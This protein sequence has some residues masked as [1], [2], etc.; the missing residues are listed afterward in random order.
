M[1]SSNQVLPSDYTSESFPSANTYFNNYDPQSNYANSYSPQSSYANNANPQSLYSNNRKM[2]MEELKERVFQNYLNNLGS[3]GLNG[4][5]NGLNL[6]GNSLDQ[7]LDIGN[8][9][10][11][12]Y[13]PYDRGNFGSGLNYG[14]CTEDVISAPILV[15]VLAGLAL[16]W[17]VLRE[18]IWQ[19]G[20]RRKKRQ[21]EEDEDQGGIANLNRFLFGNNSK[22]IT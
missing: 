15:T 13:D 20:G 6:V 7:G 21:V 17:W 5:S 10:Y 8:Q 22:K 9:N 14:Y 18:K 11:Q 3:A 1:T 16:M 12:T 4:I 2:E 19:N